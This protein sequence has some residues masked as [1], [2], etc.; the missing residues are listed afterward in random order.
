[1]HI[2]ACA[3]A[4]FSFFSNIFAQFSCKHFLESYHR[5]KGK[6]GLKI[7]IT[8]IKNQSQEK[9]STPR[10]ELFPSLLKSTIKSVQIRVGKKDLFSQL[11]QSMGY[12]TV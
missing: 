8:K 7:K 11:C 5:L 12:N 6:I 2:G 1:M 4:P 9:K 3:T 10:N